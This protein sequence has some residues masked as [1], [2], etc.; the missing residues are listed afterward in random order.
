M[1]RGCSPPLKP[2]SHSVVW[3]APA[4]PLPLARVFEAF[5][6]DDNAPS[7]NELAALVLAG[8][9]RATAALVWSHAHADKPLPRAGDPS[10]V[11]DFSGRALCVI[12]ATRVAVT[13]FDRVSEELAATCGPVAWVKP[14]TSA[15]L[16]ACGR[17][18]RRSAASFDRQN[19]T[20]SLDTWVRLPRRHGG[21]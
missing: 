19:R 6:F 18:Q 21:L 2:R 3:A 17:V 10:I 14:Q 9:K 5:H 7:A 12:E 4:N 16:G 8:R 13:P 15:V 11:S 1:P 20:R